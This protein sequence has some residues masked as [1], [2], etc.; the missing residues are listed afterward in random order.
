MG[1]LFGDFP[2]NVQDVGKGALIAFGPKMSLF[3]CPDQLCRDAHA[4]TATTH[5]ALEQIANAQL[6]TNLGD[7]LLCAFVPHDGGARDHT[8]LARL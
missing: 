3:G 5:A 6:P 2:L 1:N 7:V 4:V 8:E